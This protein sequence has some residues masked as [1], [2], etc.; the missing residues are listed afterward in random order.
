MNTKCNV[1]RSAFIVSLLSIVFAVIT[2]CHKLETKLLMAG[3]EMPHAG[4]LLTGAG[5]DMPIGIYVAPPFNYTLDVQ[6]QYIRDANIDIIQ[7]IAGWIAPVDKL[8]MLDMA[9]NH[10]LKMVVADDRI[11][12]TNADITA[13]VNDYVNHPALA[14]YYVRDEPVVSQLQ[15]AANR[16]QKL[17]TLDNNHDPHVNLLPS[18]ATGALGSINYEQDY[19]EAW[20]QK[21]EP[22]NLRYLSLDNYPFLS[23]GT[24]REVPYF[25]DLDVL[26]RVGLKYH[27]KTSAYL[28]SIGSSIGLRRPDA[29]ELRYSAYT[30]L[31]YGVKRPVWFTYWT[32]TGGSETYTNAIVDASGNKTDLYVPFQALNFEMKQLGKTLVGLD[33]IKVYHSGTAIPAGTVRPPANFVWQPQNASQAMII[34]QLT[35]PVSGK[36]YIMVVNKSF[37]SNNTFAFTIAS[38]VANVKVV[39]KVTSLEEATNFVL[40]TH[41]MSDTFL[42]GEG[43]LYALEK[44]PFTT[45]VSTLAG[46]GI[47]GFNDGQGTAAKFNFT[48][49]TGMATDANGNIYVADV[50]NHCIRKITPAG[51]VS[52]LA[53]NPGVAGK[54]DGTGT[55]ALFDHPSAVAVD[56]NNNVFVADTWNWGI[57]KITPA[58][59]VTTV[60]TWVLPFPQGITVDKNNGKLYAVSALPA[61]SQNKL[62]EV[63]PAGVMTTRTLS[64]PVLSGGIAM[65]SQGNLVIADNGSSSIYKVNT[66]TWVV[67]PVAGLS[68]QTGQTD[69]VGSAARFEHPW[70]VAVDASDNIY[71]AGCGHLFDAPTI[72]DSAS[73]IRRIEAGTNKVTTIAGLSQGY[74]DGA[75]NLARFTVPTGIALGSGGAI[76]VLDR[77]N[78]RIRKVLPQ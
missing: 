5:N 39:S 59:V 67:T 28:Q 6:Y 23:N 14:G 36:E 56:A 52:T 10:G 17:L 76:Y 57:R 24:F 11:N 44:A 51:L 18:Y 71:V 50:N 13:L 77:F 54:T 1:K 45:M 40:A 9:A 30:H 63:S 61:V 7:D 33:A 20:I 42:P 37:T 62:Y 58:G 15:D 27:I 48:T 31:A 47:A 68:G 78:Q 8:T 29:N 72:A 19:I 38:T 16:Y 60:I 12:G 26:R 73:S 22:A 35:D 66:S 65:D 41:T 49:N 25:N 2:G 4:A 64:V 55:A 3:K 69:G 32:P 53:G 34:S 43:K 21:V 70:G 46:A 74:V 75:G